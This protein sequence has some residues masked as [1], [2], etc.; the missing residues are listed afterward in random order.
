MKKLLRNIYYFLPVQLF[1]LHFK[2]YQVLLL[3]WFILYSTVGGSFLKS[4]GAQGL[5]LSPEYWGKVDF[6]SFLIT[7]VAMGVFIMAWQITTF[8]LHS[9]RFK[10]L[11][12]TSNPFLKYSI[13]NN[14]L[15][16]IFLVYYLFS[17][18]HYNRDI[19]LKS[20]LDILMLIAGLLF[21][22]TISWA[23]SFVYFFGAE[24]TI[25]RRMTPLV[26]NPELLRKRG[27]EKIF[28]KEDLGQHVNYYLSS[29]FR[30]R[31]PRKVHH[32]REDFLE[33]IFK[34][35]HIAAIVSILLA[36]I[37]LIIIGVF[38]ENPFFEIPAFSSVLVFLGI[39]VAAIGALTYFLQNWSLPMAIL[40]I[41]FANF[42]Y[43][44]EYIDAR[45]KA[46][47]LNYSKKLPRTSYNKFQLNALCSPEHIKADKANM[48]RI[49][50]RW[51]AHQKEEKPKMVF[52]NVSG[53]GLRSAAFV[54]N[55]L[56]KIDSLYN[57]QLFKKTFMISGASGGMLA[58]TYYRELYRE[59]FH[60]KDINLYDTTYVDNIS[61]DLLNAIFS[62]MITRDIF[63]PALKFSVGK[64]HYV[65]DRGYAF[66][67]KLALNTFN[68]LNVQL[69]DVEADEGQ[70]NVPLMIF[71]SVIKRDGRRMIISSQPVSFM[72]KA[73]DPNAEPDGVDFKSLFHDRN[74]QNL[75]ILS[76]LRMNATF[77]YVL[78]N[79]WLPTEPVIDVM[80]AGLRDNYGLETTLRF[81]EHFKDWIATNT[82]GIVILQIKDK[83]PD[84][85]QQ[86]FETNSLT[87]MIINPATVLQHNW[88]KMQ[89]YS[90]LD[91]ISYFQAGSLFPVDRF[92]MVYF[93]KKESKMASLNFHLSARERLDIQQSFH[94][95]YN[96]YQLQRFLGTL[97]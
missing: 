91:Q 12:T 96:Q 9:R 13:N 66:E 45:N 10:F 21:G 76:A 71:N 29:F 4:F 62:S 43:K 30:I 15:P 61:R 51:K 23:V 70:G 75:R 24:K 40:L 31:K 18:Y 77:P 93:P 60:G 47:G 8:I 37:F 82:S 34:Q 41:I 35:H 11:A 95:P 39:A 80:D 28:W 69:K 52:I 90:Q 68:V 89:G 57:G 64:M 50:N 5:I 55:N 97:K 53:G 79:V 42:L 63:A 14:L 1:V 85:W 22:I 84:N 26:A 32:Y 88:F 58:A 73:V 92:T 6:V 59:K 81:A 36:F 54:M 19:E 7:G 16:I 83:L 94:H 38:L 65:K 3:P 49:L 17:V 78:P 86:Q 2:K 44:Y 27:P 48:I 67:R 56:Q 72:M 33:K 74:P 20:T 25:V 46:Y 87:D